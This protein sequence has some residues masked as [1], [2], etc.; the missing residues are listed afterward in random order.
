MFFLIKSGRAVATKV[1]DFSKEVITR[2]FQYPD[3]VGITSALSGQRYTE[4]VKAFEELEVIPL[5][6]EDFIHYLQQD[7]PMMFHFISKM[8]ADQVKS[9]ERLLLQAYGTVRHKLAFVLIDLFKLYETDGK[10]II[11]IPREDLAAMTGTA[12]ETIIRSLSE[13]K[14]EGLVAISGTDIIIESIRPIID[15]RY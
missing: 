8:A 3:V 11:T 14:E 9:D 15:M 2:I 6:T 7:R 4:T 10:A 13:F 5:K 12:K 1:D